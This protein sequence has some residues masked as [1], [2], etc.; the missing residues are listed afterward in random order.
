MIPLRWKIWGL[1]ALAF[2]AGMVGLRA[3][4]ISRAL[5]RARTKGLEDA[6]HRHD[7][8]N[9][10]DNRIAAERD[11]RERLRDDWSR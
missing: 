3:A 8:R 1:A 9:E 4:A 5:D 6:L 7:I 2:V 11:A 10:V